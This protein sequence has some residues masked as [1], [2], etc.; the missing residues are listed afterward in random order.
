MVV[1]GLVACSEQQVTSM[2]PVTTAEPAVDAVVPSEEPEANMD[3]LQTGEPVRIQA[4]PERVVRVVTDHQ[5]GS[6]VFLETKDNRI[7]FATALHVVEGTEVAELML[8]SDEESV[9]AS[10]YAVRGL[11]LAFLQVDAEHVKDILPEFSAFFEEV[12]PLERGKKIIATGYNAEGMQL[13]YEG[14]VWEPW[15]YAEDFQSHMLLCECEAVPGMSGGGVFDE[16]DVFLGIVCGLNDNGQ[17]AVL[18]SNVIKSEYDLFV[19]N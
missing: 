14:V 1:L 6:A 19:N 5:M 11:D 15:I 9:E 4:G 16:N 13:I 10:V 17:L 8:L 2:P 18:P 12:K 7:I 3:N